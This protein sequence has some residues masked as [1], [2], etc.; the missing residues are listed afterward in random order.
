M[1]G[2]AGYILIITHCF[3]IGWTYIVLNHNIFFDTTAA[4]RR[5][6]LIYS[7]SPRQQSLNYLGALNEEGS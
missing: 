4:I 1:S 6:L 3:P 5:I 2:H 7:T